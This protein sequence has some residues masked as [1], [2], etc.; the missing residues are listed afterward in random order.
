MDLSIVIVSFNTKED[1]R[2][3]LE[4]VLGSVEGLNYEI[5]VVDNGSS[6]D[7]RSL[8]GKYATRYKNIY[9]VKNSENKGFPEANN[10]GVHKSRGKYVLFLNSDTIVKKDAIKGIIKWMEGNR[11]VGIASCGLVN[12]DGSLQGTGGYFPTLLR[13]FSW[14]IIQDLPLVDKLIKPF[15]PMKEKA[16]KRG[17][18]FYQK[19]REVDWVTGAFMMVRREVIEGGV[20]WDK[21]YFMYTEDV[22]YCYQA[23]KRGWKVRYVPKWRVVHLGGI[24]GTKEK[25]ILGEYRGVRR[26]Y[27]KYYPKWQY[28]IVRSCLKVGALGRVVIFG[29][30]EG[31]KSAQIYAKAFREG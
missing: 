18:Q 14:M 2:R 11:K 9:L 31:R 17:E 6:D 27:R 21:E 4:S 16:G 13:V 24:S 5:V 19:E 28:P 15:H 1:T 30:I 8:L 25:T 26:F 29:I 3:C 10:I 23:K 12:R 22:D 7:S 20:R